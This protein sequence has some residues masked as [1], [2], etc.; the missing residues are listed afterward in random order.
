[1]LHPRSQPF[2]ELTYQV[3]GSLPPNAPTYIQRPADEQL[4]RGLLGGEFCYVLTSRQMGKS[5]LRVAVMARLRTLGVQCSTLD[6]TSIGSQHVTI[7]QWYAAIAAILSKQLPLKTSLRPWWRERLDL[8]PAARLAAFIEEILLPETQGPLVILIDEIDSIL[9]LNFPTDDFFALIRTCYNQ[10]AEVPDYRRL[11]FALFGVATSGDLIADKQRTP[12]NIGQAIELKGFSPEAIAPL[13]SGLTA[14]FPNPQQGLE[15]IFHWTQGQPF[16]MQKLC[17]Q[18]LQQSPKFRLPDPHPSNTSETL[19]DLCVQKR[20]VEHWE[21]QDSPEHLKT[22]RDRLLYNDQ[23]AAELLSLYRRIWQG[24]ASHGQASTIPAEDSPQQQELLLSGLVDAHNGY[25]QVK[26]PIYQQVFNLPWIESHLQRL[27]PYASLLN[28]WLESHGEDSSRL[29]RGKALQEALDW[30]QRKSLSDVDYRY[31]SASQA[32]EQQERQ[33]KD[34]FERQT[35]QQRLEQE[36]LRESQRCLQLQTQN[37]QRQRQFLGLLGV[38]LVGS[39]GLGLANFR[40]YQRSAL[41]EVSAF[42]AA[43]QGSYTSEQQLDALVQGLQ[44]RQTLNQLQF[45]SSQQRQELH[46][47]TQQIL[48]QAIHANHETNRMAAHPGGVLG[49]DVSPDGQWIATSGPDGTAKLWQRDGTLV[50]TLPVGSTVY[51]V[52][53]SPD[54]QLLATPSLKGDIYLW[55]MDGDLQTHLRGHEAAVWHLAWSPQ[56]DYLLSVSSDGTLRQ[57]SREGQLLHTLRQHG[58][59][60]WNV[61]V[62]PQGKE[63]ASIGSD[64]TIIRWQWDGTLINRFSEGI[65]SGWAIAYH[66]QTHLLAAGYSDHQIRLWQPDG[67]LVRHLQGHGAEVGTLVFNQDGSSLASGSADGSLKLWSEDGTLRNN[68]Q[69]HRSRLRG[70]AFSPDG[71]EVLSAGEDG[72][73]RIWQVDNDFMEPLGGHDQEVWQAQYFPPLI[74]SARLFSHPITARSASV[75]SSR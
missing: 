18:L 19:V 17:Q 13:V 22:I 47:Q 8:P 45:L 15:R 68:L 63:F 74:S 67:T 31:L 46:R 72:F 54:S 23:R 70:V 59:T 75:E 66:P 9:A 50:H 11:S 32:L 40:A 2:L 42:M 7:E 12:F 52:Q 10:R 61:A 3:G 38:T 69:G 73:V 62:H 16:L 30:T 57:W 14:V 49:V 35:I 26:N 21:T 71:R 25:L 33:Q 65:S 51:S 20:I 5:S 55:S 6:L 64:G 48:E 53:F 28:A 34:A 56:G 39:M 60:V 58:G 29:L 36:R 43:S 1:M 27:R 41:S 24:S 44:A 37:V 4:F